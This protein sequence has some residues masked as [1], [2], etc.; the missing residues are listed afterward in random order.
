M[1]AADPD[2][3]RHCSTSRAPV[4]HSRFTLFRPGVL[5]LL[6]ALLFVGV[7]PELAPETQFILL[8]II[9]LLVLVMYFTQFARH[10]PSFLEA[11]GILLT[12]LGF[13][14]L[15]FKSAFIAAT[16]IITLAVA[17]L[18][19]TW[20]AKHWPLLRGLTTVALFAMVLRPMLVL[21]LAEKHAS[22]FISLLDV[23][24]LLL[25]CLLASIALASSQVMSPQ[26]IFPWQE[27]QHRARLWST[28]LFI[29]VFSE[30]I[31]GSG[32]RHSQAITS[33]E[34]LFSLRQYGD[35]G[36]T[37]LTVAIA[38]KARLWLGRV[39][40]LRWIP[41]A[42]MIMPVN[43]VI[44]GF[45][46]VRPEENTWITHF[47][48]LNGLGI[49]ILCFLITASIWSSTPSTGVPDQRPRS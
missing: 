45:Y 26:P 49:L 4:R 34:F 8:R 31:I 9:E 15:V 42:L 24:D 32:M 20:I 7:A 33:G 5:A 35:I 47:H 6:A 19:M 43:Q 16:F 13:L 41:P 28:V 29:S 14:F 3:D 44:L 1:P 46:L 27:L 23:F 25:L 17:W 36:I 30:N 2:L 10:S 39:P 21:L 18:I 22:T 40:G 38:W 12:S 48:A 11:S 37:I